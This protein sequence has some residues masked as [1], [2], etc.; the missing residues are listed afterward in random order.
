MAINIELNLKAIDRLFKRLK[1][2]KIKI[3][4]YCEYVS[5]LPKWNQIT[6]K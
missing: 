3:K 5:K 4:A 2:Q 6:S 1:H